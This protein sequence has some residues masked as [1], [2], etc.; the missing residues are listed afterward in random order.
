MSNDKK[1]TPWKGPVIGL[2]QQGYPTPVF[3]DTH[4]AINMKSKSGGIVIVGAPGSG[5]TQ[6]GESLAV[7]SGLSG[8]KTIY[9]DPKNDAVGLSELKDE[10]DGHLD[11]R[12]LNSGKKDGSMDPLITEIDPAKKVAKTLALIEI[13]VGELSEE[14]KISL[15]PIVTDVAYGDDPSLTLLVQRLQRHK[16]NAL[17][18]IGS[19]LRTMEISNPISGL[20]FKRSREKTVIKDFNDGLTVLIILGLKMPS[21]GSDPKQYKS[22]ERLSLGIMYLIVE[23]LLST[24]SDQNHK[25]EPKTILIDEAWAFIASAAGRNAVSSMFRLGR[26]MNTACILMTQNL[27]DLQAPGDESENNSLLN[28]AVTKFAFRTDDP[29]EIKKLCENLGISYAAFGEQFQELESGCCI[30]KDY[31]GRVSRIYIIQ[32]NE[33]WKHAFETNPLKKQQQQE[34]IA[35]QEEE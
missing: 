7:M 9:V 17:A 32:Q 15:P 21:P 6:L 3:F 16:D 19:T 12:D 1:T 27:S 34:A 22:E 11:I 14:Q 25:L 28:S 5:K 2:N 35:S 30:M 10:F 29:N 8:K 31:L 26:S 23:F 33:R 4:T 18:A 13:L 20:L 24:M